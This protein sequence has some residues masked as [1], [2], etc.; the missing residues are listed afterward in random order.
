M[1]RIISY[2]FA[3]LIMTGCNDF[4]ARKTYKKCLREE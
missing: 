1:K 2:V 4:Y 3:G